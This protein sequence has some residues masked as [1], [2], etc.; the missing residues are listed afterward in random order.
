MLGREESGEEF[1]RRV[2]GISA[3]FSE[4]FLAVE[5]PGDRQHVDTAYP[6]G[7]NITHFVADID[8]LFRIEV[9]SDEG[10]LERPWFS[11]DPAA[12]DEIE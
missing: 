12:F 6:A 10:F 1:G 3:G 11:P 7:F 9:S 5:S 2:D 4:R 8:D